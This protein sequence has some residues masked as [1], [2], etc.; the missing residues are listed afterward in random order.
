[1]NFWF[2]LGVPTLAT[3]VTLI[4]GYFVGRRGRSNAIATTV[5]KDWLHTIA[6]D[7][8]EFTE[9]QIDIIWKRWRLR[10]FERTNPKT[11]SGPYDKEAYSVLE[12]SSW[13]RTFRSDL[14][15]TKLLL[16]L[17]DSD[18]LQEKLIKTIEEYAQP[19]QDWAKELG[20]LEKTLPEE[21]L[22][23]RGFYY[24]VLL[25]K[26]RGQILTAGRH[27]LAAKRAAIRKSI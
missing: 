13:T 26:R 3:T 27:V 6:E 9:L 16:M 1:M 11:S 23:E 12:E 18:A 17:D 21:K 14:L 2:Q 25:R 8:A 24:D 20:K 5:E 15:K 22:T 7:L 19:A 10:D 4:V